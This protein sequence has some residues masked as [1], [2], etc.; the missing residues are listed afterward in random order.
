MMWR[1][2][3]VH[4][5]LVDTGISSKYGGTGQTFNWQAGQ[6]SVEEISRIGQVVVAGGLNAG[7]V[8]EAVRILKPWGVDVSSGVEANTG[9]K[10]P[11]K[12]RAF[13]DAVRQADKK[14]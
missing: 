11:R 2:D 8:T 9:K 10:D 12:I 13:V 6:P 5:F 1:P 3:V 14:N 4:A 7:N